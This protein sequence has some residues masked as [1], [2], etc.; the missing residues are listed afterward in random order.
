[1]SLYHQEDA[2]NFVKPVIMIKLLPSLALFCG[3]A[4]RTLMHLGCVN[5]PFKSRGGIFQPLT[6]EPKPRKTSH[7]CL[8]C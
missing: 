8:S 6:I 3:G 2:H 5:L 4:M 1:M 7:A